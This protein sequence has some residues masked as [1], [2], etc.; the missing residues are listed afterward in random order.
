MR[1]T[2]RTQGNSLFEFAHFR[3]NS[4]RSSEEKKKGGGA[5]NWGT[6]KDELD[7]LQIELGK[8][9]DSESPEMKYITKPVKQ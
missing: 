2:D 1:K 7:E 6:V 3:R 4:Y 8:P 5:H 9:Y